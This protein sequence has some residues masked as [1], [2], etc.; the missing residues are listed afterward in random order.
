MR[1]HDTASN[2]EYHPG[3]NTAPAAR[4]TYRNIAPPLLY[5]FRRLLGRKPAR[6]QDVAVK[7]WEVAPGIDE[8][9]FSIFIRDDHLLRIKSSANNE[10]QAEVIATIRPKRHVA[11]PATAYLLKD[12]VINGKFLHCGMYRDDLFRC[13]T[14]PEDH[15]WNRAPVIDHAVFTGLYASSRWF[16]HLLHDEFSLQ[17]LAASMGPQVSHRRPIYPDEPRWR[18]LQSLPPPDF[19]HALLARELIVLHDIGQ[20]PSKRQRY[21]AQRARFANFPAGHERIYL[22]RPAT[23]GARRVLVNEDELI[24]RLRREGFVIVTPTVGGVDEILR[25]CMHAKIV[26]TPDG[27]HAGPIFF[28]GANG[29]HCFFLLPPQRATSLM[30]QMAICYGMHAGLYIG[31]QRNNDESA[32]QVDV[33]EVLRTLDEFITA[34]PN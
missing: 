31:T 24:L 5:K 19:H 34:R 9:P 20:N 7:S 12:A 13:E 10:T 32:F 1:R 21:A 27:S 15:W 2:S 30:A 25:L 22:R 28:F 16:G 14:R 4:R 6:L 3:M 23:G 29:A 8:P 17:M 33:D 11:A 26:I 18:E